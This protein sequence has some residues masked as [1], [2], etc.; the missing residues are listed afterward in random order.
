MAFIAYLVIALILYLVFKY[1]EDK[2]I[3]KKDE[4]RYRTNINNTYYTKRALLST[5]Y[6]NTGIVHNLCS[7]ISEYSY[8]YMITW[9]KQIYIYDKKSTIY[10]IDDYRFIKYN[11]LQIEFYNISNQT[12][13]KSFNIRKY[14]ISYAISSVT[15]MRSKILLHYYNNVF[16]LYDLKKETLENINYNICDNDKVIMI[17]YYKDMLLILYRRDHEIRLTISSND[18]NNLFIKDFLCLMYGV[19]IIV[20]ADVKYDQLILLVDHTYNKTK[21]IMCISFNLMLNG[22]DSKIKLQS[23][24]IFNYD[25]Y[26]IIDELWFHIKRNNRI[27]LKF[28]NSNKD[29]YIIEYDYITGKKIKLDVIQQSMIFEKLYNY[30]INLNN[31]DKMNLI[32]ENELVQISRIVI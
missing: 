24:K 21:N 8:D 18:Y 27:C 6:N 4:I 30:R 15:Y 32:R 12:C 5:I 11:N 29:H 13:I 7:I 3:T 20:H 28:F 2:Y 1:Y 17:K 23:Q 16:M 14:D 26:L 22:Y 19:D 9:S 10:L 31:S 25:E